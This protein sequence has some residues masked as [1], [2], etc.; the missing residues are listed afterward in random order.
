MRGSAG[1]GYPAS[2]D[3]CIF[4]TWVSGVSMVH[5]TCPSCGNIY[6]LREV[7]P[8]QVYRCL[9]CASVLSVPVSGAAVE[10]PER[11]A[12]I[13]RLEPG[14]FFGPYVIVRER[15]RGGMGIVYE[16]R[17]LQGGRT[18]AL[19]TLL[20]NPGAGPSDPEEKRFLR[21]ARTHE[22]LPPHP[23]VVRILGAGV[24][25]GT[26][27]LAME[28]VDGRPLQEWRRDPAVSLRGEVELLRDAAL[29]V[30]HAH[31][32]GVIHRDLKPENVMVDR[33]GRPRVTDFGLARI[34][35][36]GEQGS[37]TASNEV[38]GT[39]P[40]VSPEQALKPK[41]VDA[42]TDV[43]ALGVMLYEALT[44]YLPYRGKSGIAMLMSILHD[45]VTPPRQTP[46][47]K[48]NPQVDPEIERVCLRAMAKKPED[49]P[50]AA[51]EF[52]EDLTRWLK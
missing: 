16:A 51:Q 2:A 32:H 33:E 28:F 25:A 29:G 52:A 35:G 30:H 45:P 24:V 11:P 15:G 43:Y 9:A 6:P 13:S 46:R 5:L 7:A 26:A 27:Y 50:L 4:K 22:A 21:E 3:G 8:G 44:G 10:L 47:G 12:S 39:P 36:K 38:V 41:S 20:M 48:A 17:E 34:V 18:V 1:I 14:S 23:F 40:Y 19:K 31:L 49:R 37:S 42:R